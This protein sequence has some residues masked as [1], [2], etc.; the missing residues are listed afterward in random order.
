MVDAQKILL[1]LISLKGILIMFGID[2]FSNEQAEAI[3]NGVAAIVAV[4]IAIINLVGKKQAET[5]LSEMKQAL[6]KAATD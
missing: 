5:E 6:V 1:G 4:V 3:A 2:I